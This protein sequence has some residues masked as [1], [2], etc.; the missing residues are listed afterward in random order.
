[1]FF[2]IIIIRLCPGL[3]GGPLQGRREVPHLGDIIIRRR[4]TTMIII[5]TIITTIVIVIVIVIV[6]IQIIITILALLG[7]QNA[8]MN[9][10]WSPVHSYCWKCGFRGLLGAQGAV[11][12]PLATT[13]VNHFLRGLFGVDFLGMNSLGVDFCQ[14]WISWR[15]FVGVDFVSTTKPPNR[16]GRMHQQ[17]NRFLLPQN[18]PPATM[19]LCG[20][21]AQWPCHC[22][23]CH[24][25]HSHVR[26]IGCRAP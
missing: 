24:F 20:P 17:I 8:F 3:R 2:T 12:C 19:L 13:H 26:T 4:R 6:I 5:I 23:S 7:G 21:A 22:C 15:G 10:W 25:S 11:G 16:C 1:M 9:R 14:A 18:P